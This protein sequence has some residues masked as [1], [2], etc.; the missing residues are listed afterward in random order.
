MG[1]KYKALVVRRDKSSNIF[2]RK[3]EELDIDNLPNNDILIKVRYS[4]INYKDILSSYGNPGVTRKFPHTP[5]IDAAGVIVK[6]CVENFKV[7]EEVIIIGQLLGMTTPGGFGEYISVPM[8]WVTRKPSNLTL[9]ECMIIGTAGFTAALAV[10]ELIKQNIKSNSGPIVISG[11]TGGVS[12]ILIAIL[13]K[14]GYEVHAFTN[15]VEHEKFLLAIGAK[16]VKKTELL[17]DKSGMPQLKEQW[18]AGIDTIG[19]NILTTMLKSIKKFGLVMTIGNIESQNLNVSLMPF[20]LR[21]IK[22]IGINSQ[23][24]DEESK[25]ILWQK[26]STIWKPNCLDLISRTITINELNSEIE[27][28]KNGLNFGRI[29][30]KY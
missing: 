29:V 20:I 4:S 1:L 10:N 26:I 23:E 8:N 24:L 19:G 21:G 5:G 27:N 6:S 11:S 15:K 18:A 16:D 14:I 22:L 25:N 2:E 30:L 17:N 13:N 7:G 28:S 9:K 3:I 12:S